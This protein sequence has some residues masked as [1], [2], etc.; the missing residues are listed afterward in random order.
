MCRYQYQARFLPQFLLVFRSSFSRQGNPDT[1]G[2][3]HE[4]HQIT[5]RANDDGDQQV[6]GNHQG[7]EYLEQ[8]Q[9]HGNGE[10]RLAEQGGG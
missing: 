7:G 5:R 4:I 2:K 8:H 10:R 3:Q 1:R 6:I 9:H